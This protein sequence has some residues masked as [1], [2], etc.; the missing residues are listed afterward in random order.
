[1]TRHLI[2]PATDLI[3][4]YIQANIGTALSAIRT[5][6]NSTLNRGIPTPVPNE[7]FIAKNY[8]SFQPPAIFIICNRVDMKK[9][10]GANHINATAEYTIAAVSEGQTTTETTRIT[11]RY[12]AALSQILD[13]LRLTSSDNSFS[14]KLIVKNAEF[15]EDYEVSM[16]EGN[17]AKRWRKGVTLGVDVEFYESL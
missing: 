8:V 12:Q 3:Q 6:R 15:S 13:N 2:E 10:R 9:D 11:W 4:S 17:P 14:I 16:K 7:Y 1:M 5:D